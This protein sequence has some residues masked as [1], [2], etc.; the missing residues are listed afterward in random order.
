[1]KKENNVI[2]FF[3]WT[4]FDEYKMKEAYVGQMLNMT[5]PVDKGLKER[6]INLC[7]L[8]DKENHTCLL[9]RCSKR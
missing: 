8:K 2:V 1:M 7:Y 5:N 3:I 4:D 9:V 6:Q